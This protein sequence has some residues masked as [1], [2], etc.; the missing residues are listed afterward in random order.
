MKTKKIKLIPLEQV[1]ESRSTQELKQVN[2]LVN[3]YMEEE[4]RQIPGYDNYQ[5]SSK[6]RLRTNKGRLLKPWATDKGYLRCALTK[7]YK[8]KAQ[9]FFIHRLV[10]KAF[11]P[12]VPGKE[13]INHIDRNSAN[14]NVENLE[15]CDNKYNI[16]HSC[17]GQRYKNTPRKERKKR[18]KK[19]PEAVRKDRIRIAR[20]LMDEYH[21]IT[22]EQL[23]NI[24]GID[25]RDTLY[26]LAEF[27]DNRTKFNSKIDDSDT[28]Y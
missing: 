6:G 24:I 16:N 12:Q 18:E 1:L 28:Q 9:L 4:W 5:I 27:M 15:W 20:E 2:A 14:N 11:I 17:I 21:N 23:L 26:T 3:Q 10:A 8:G 25:I 22:T 7:E 19:I 13:Y